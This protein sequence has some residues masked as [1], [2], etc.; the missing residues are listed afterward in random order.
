MKPPTDPMLT[1]N[2][3]ADLAG[4]SIRSVRRLVALR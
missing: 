1:Y 3:V 4:I 2:E